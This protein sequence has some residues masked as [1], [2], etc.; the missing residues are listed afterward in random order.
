LRSAI[1]IN[2][3][4]DRTGGVDKYKNIG[5]LS[6]NESEKVSGNI[7]KIKGMPLG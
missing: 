4:V 2:R 7:I 6:W 5:E 3:L 1:K